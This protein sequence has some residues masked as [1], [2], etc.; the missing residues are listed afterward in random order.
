MSSAAIAGVIFVSMIVLIMLGV[1]IAL[2]MLPAAL[3]G[4]TLIGSP[5]MVV[6]QFS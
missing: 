5:Q 2:T 6:S 3:I 1:P 4:F